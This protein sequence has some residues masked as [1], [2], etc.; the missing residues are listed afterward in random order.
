VSA[1]SRRSTAT[2]VDRFLPLHPHEFAVLSVLAEGVRHGYDIIK[3]IEP[4]AGPVQPADVYRRIRRL[5]SAGVIALAAP[6][7]PA[8]AD[9]RERRFYA[10][11]P[12]GWAVA[13]AEAARLQSLVRHLRGHAL[14]ATPGS[15][16][17]R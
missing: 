17:G 8:I 11:T 13:R 7:R 14:L 2:D 6:P 1:P 4:I 10:L 9:D 12:L 5:R 15:R 3:Q 16:K